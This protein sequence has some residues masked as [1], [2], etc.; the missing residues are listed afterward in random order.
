MVGIKF[1][2]FALDW[3]SAAEAPLFV[4]LVTKFT[5]RI[6]ELGPIGEAEKM[7]R[8]ELLHKIS[9]AR[10]AVESVRL[11]ARLGKVA[12]DLRLLN[13]Y[14]PEVIEAQMTEK[15]NDIIMRELGKGIEALG[16]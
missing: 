16:S 5:N 11:R 12:T 4:D 8:D 1:E 9:A 14:T 13:H 6:K 7:P 2:R 15:I 3:A 10:S